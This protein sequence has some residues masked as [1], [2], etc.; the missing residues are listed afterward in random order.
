MLRL[1][2]I[3]NL[4][5]TALVVLVVA[6]SATASAGT[7]YVYN[8]QYAF[9]LE[10]GDYYPAALANAPTRTYDGALGF[11]A[12]IPD[13]ATNDWLT[14]TF[15]GA[16]GNGAWIGLYKQ[17]GSGN[18]TAG[19]GTRAWVNGITPEQYGYSNYA[20]GAPGPNGQWATFMLSDGTWGTSEGS[21]YRD[22]LTEY[23]LSASDTP[24]PG[25]LLIAGAGLLLLSLRRRN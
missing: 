21:I 17:D 25:T 14:A 3:V 16:V 4:V 10:N 20:A 6:L 19:D 11:L 12:I 23:K 9:S 18:P 2:S 15:G 22:A 24:E 5:I 8:N 13:Q 1:S 7:V